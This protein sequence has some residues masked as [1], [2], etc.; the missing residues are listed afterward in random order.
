MSRRSAF[1]AWL[2]KLVLLA[3]VL[4]G[5]GLSYAT[6]HFC[7]ASHTPVGAHMAVADH[8]DAT[9]THFKTDADPGPVVLCLAAVAAILVMIVL[10]LF[11]P[12]RGSS[13]AGSGS[14]RPT[15]LPAVRGSPPL[16]ALVL[17]R[18][19]VLRI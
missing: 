3:F 7:A 16:F 9:M 12:G 15:A 1:S 14:K 10:T 6:A 18:V 4:M 8:P 2:P 5:V 11:G 19:A 17:R 13:T